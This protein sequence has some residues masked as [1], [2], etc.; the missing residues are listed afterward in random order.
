MRGTLLEITLGVRAAVRQFLV[1]S[2]QYY[3]GIAGR[4]FEVNE[5]AQAA[6]DWANSHDGGAKEKFL[7][8]M[9]VDTAKEH[10]Q[11]N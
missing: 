1:H 10:A 6:H 2:T 7:F 3:T 4:A 8:V 9:E 11:R 5:A